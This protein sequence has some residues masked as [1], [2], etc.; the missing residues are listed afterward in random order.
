VGNERLITTLHDSLIV[1]KQTI[2]SFSV[3][4]QR[5]S[6]FKRLDGKHSLIDC[7]SL[8]ELFTDKF[9]E[10]QFVMLGCKRNLTLFFNFG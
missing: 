10:N 4:R 2:I 6:S 7:V 5:F 9:N 8:R 3:D 1:N